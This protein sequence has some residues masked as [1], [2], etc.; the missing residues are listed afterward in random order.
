MLDQIA[1]AQGQKTLSKAEAK[2]LVDYYRP[3]PSFPPAQ[4]I[5]GL[6]FE[7]LWDGII[8]EP[9]IE[10]RSSGGLILVKGT[11]VDDIQRGKVVGIGPGIYKENGVFVPV[12]L[13]LGD[14][15]YR[16][17]RTHA[18]K[19]RIK[20]PETGKEQEYLMLNCRDVVAVSRKPETV[21]VVGNVCRNVSKE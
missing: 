7:P 6:E 3:K 15:I 17:A 19:V 1:E 16:H 5:P 13:S 9:I 21:H 14:V 10:E 12:P 11:G 2:E 8:V 18:S 4:V 20:N